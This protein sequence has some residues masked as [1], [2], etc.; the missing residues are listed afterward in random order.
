MSFTKHLESFSDY[1]EQRTFSPRTIEA[2]TRHAKEFVAFLA[3]YYP[4]VARPNEVTREI[5]DDYQHYVRELTTTTGRPLAN[6]TVRLK[7]TAVKR[8]F[9]HLIEGDLVLKDPTT[10][11]APPKEEQRLT[12]S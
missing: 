5:V 3:T 9:A 12:R 2:Y 1:L 7:L 10:I 8:L 6:A 4:K 11:I